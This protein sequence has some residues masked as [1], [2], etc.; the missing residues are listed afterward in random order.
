[1]ETNTARQQ[2]FR[3]RELS[4]FDVETTGTQFGYHEIVEIAA[5]RTTPDGSELGKLS[6][7]VMPQHPERLTDAARAVNGFSA[8]KWAREA[9]DPVTAFSELAALTKGSIAIA[10]NPTFD[11]AFISIRI[12]ELGLPSL[13]VDHHWIGT[14]SL[15]WPLV[16]SGTLPSPRLAEICAHFGVPVEPEPHTALAGA[17]TALRVYKKLRAVFGGLVLARAR[18]PLVSS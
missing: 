18:E 6:F 8:E 13:G 17:E 7:K 1:M 10:H 9:T 15:A 5:I 12:R 14:E 4:F 2:D 16:L 3:N 11:R